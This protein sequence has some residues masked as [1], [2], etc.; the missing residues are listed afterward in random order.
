MKTI[1][2]VDIGTNS[3]LYSLFE[4]SGKSKLNEIHF[5]RNSPRIG[6]QL[7]GAKKPRITKESYTSLLKI[8]KRV[9]KHAEKNQADSILVAATN[10]LRIAQNGKEV[11]QNLE[12][13]LGIP[14]EILTPDKEAELSFLGAA[15][16]LSGTK[17]AMIIDLGG[18]STEFVVYRGKKR[19][20]FV[21]LPEGAVSLTEQFGTTNSI[22]K[23]KYEDY[24]VCLD[25]YKKQ[26]LKI[27][28]FT[29]GPITLVGGTSSVLAWLLDNDFHT[30][31]AGKIVTRNDLRFLVDI[32]AGLDLNCRK[33][34]L[35]IDKKRAEIIF[36]GAFWLLYL[37]NTIEIRKAKASPR[38]LRHGMALEFVC[39]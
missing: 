30:N 37:F 24:T 5:E 35:T 26:V 15:G 8:L 13:D 31:K 28:K 10:P 17:E 7:K 33:K 19:K 1:A 14:I 39:E 36:A 32:L 3:V 38:G 20:S 18:G 12:W 9:V 23:T 34:L 4:I 29:S 2:S 11:K 22:D 6:S 27:A 21:S 25:R 16:P